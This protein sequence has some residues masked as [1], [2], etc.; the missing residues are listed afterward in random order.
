M[1][2]SIDRGEDAV[3]G[4]VLGAVVGASSARTEGEGNASDA[5]EAKTAIKRREN[6]VGRCTASEG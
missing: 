6:K 3:V 5:V 1:I 4:P 2:A